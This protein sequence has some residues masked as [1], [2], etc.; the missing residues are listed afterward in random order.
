[1][2]AATDSG[3]R[4]SLDLPSTTEPRHFRVRPI[5]ETEAGAVEELLRFAPGVS[6]RT[7]PVESPLAASLHLGAFDD[8]RVLRALVDLRAG[9][10]TADACFIELML[11]HPRYRRA[12]LGGALTIALL[13]R[14]HNAGARRVVLQVDDGNDAAARF[15][16]RQGFVEGGREKGRRSFE[17][18]LS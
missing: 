11:V 13:Q 17:K 18:A 12:G 6:R 5:A 3:L 16:M 4:F 10:P 14:L 1:M 8:M 15:W 2:I 9:A 7:P